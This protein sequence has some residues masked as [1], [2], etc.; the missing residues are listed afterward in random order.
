LS[1][2]WIATYILGSIGL[3]F[4]VVY[5]RD[6]K[7][8]WALIPAYVL[9][10]LALMI[11]LIDAGVLRDLVIPSYI[12][13]SIALPFFGVY[14]I[15]RKQG[16]ALIPGTIMGVIG[17]LFLISTELFKYMFPVVLIFLGIWVL[18]RVGKK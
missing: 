3:P 17:M 5:L 13:F 14:L 9:F 15:D 8:W 10:A 6:R 18:L 7:H 4:L 11:G 2:G 1:D 16:W 12:M